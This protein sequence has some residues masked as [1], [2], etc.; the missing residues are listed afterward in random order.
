MSGQ[1]RTLGRRVRAP[2]AVIALVV[3]A[4]V[5]LTVI[6]TR[7]DRGLLDP[8]SVE[9]AGGAALAA[10]LRGQGVRVDVADRPDALAATDPATTVVATVPDRLRRADLDTLARSGARLVLVAPG[11]RVLEALAPGVRPAA[12]PP[13]LLT[14][15]GPDPSCPVPAAAAAGRVDTDGE[16]Y[17]VAPP[18]VGC[19]PQAGTVALAVSGRSTVVGSATPMRNDALDRA[20]NAALAMR[21]LGAGPRLLW[22]VPPVLPD[23]SAGPTPL[24]RLVPPGWLWGGATLLLAGLVT[25]L[26]RG[27]RLGPL[28][29]ERLPV[30]VPAA[31][32]TRGRAGLYRRLGA[33]GRAAEV[34]RDD[35]R[36]RL[37][38]RV[39]VPP[40]GPAEALGAAVAAAAPGYGTAAVTDLLYGAAPADDQALV[41]LAGSLDELR[42]AVAGPGRVPA[43]E[44]RSTG[45]R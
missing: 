40:H 7:A 42:D 5:V 3:L 24:S 8:D 21:L 20:G 12:P 28:V 29:D 38:A 33:R 6:G 17:E 13:G 11:P 43:S 34:L 9:P 4:A 15:E 1:A 27:R 16:V 19:Y 31:E 35:V 2:V 37:A 36:R 32:T 41:V 10:L 39:G 22:Y 14:T 45:E 23:A 44:G 25:A 18:A 26:W 30:R